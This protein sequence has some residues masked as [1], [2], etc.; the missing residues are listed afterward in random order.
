MPL[1]SPEFVAP[2]GQL[3][4]PN[5]GGPSAEDLHARRMPTTE[6]AFGGID[7]LLSDPANA[8]ARDFWGRG[9]LMMLR[10]NSPRR[11]T[12]TLTCQ[13]SYQRPDGLT[14]F[15]MDIN[16]RDGD[17]PA[18]DFTTLFD[19]LGLTREA[20]GTVP[21]PAGFMLVR[22]PPGYYLDR[23]GLY[24]GDV[25]IGRMRNKLDFGLCRKARMHIQLARLYLP[26]WLK[27]PT[28]VEGPH[29]GPDL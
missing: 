12:K 19:L 28:Y 23:E 4:D 18:T 26:D 3:I 25:L 27:N 11:T 20:D 17:D 1:R 5:P 7:D 10:R 9:I 6:E 14:L 8:R 24:I 29:D 16:I 22:M 13:G 2:D 15:P 21:P